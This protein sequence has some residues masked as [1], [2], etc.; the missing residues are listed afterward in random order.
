MGEAYCGRL[1]CCFRFNL[2]PYV[3]YDDGKILTPHSS[4]NRTNAQTMVETVERRKEELRQRGMPAPRGMLAKAATNAALQK[5]VEELRRKLRDYEQDPAPRVSDAL[6]PVEE[7]TGAKA[8]PRAASGPSRGSARQR[9]AEAKHPP[10][11]A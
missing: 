6:K 3:D 2:G 4:I 1:V 11:G 10:G 8:R 5:R 9:S 7:T